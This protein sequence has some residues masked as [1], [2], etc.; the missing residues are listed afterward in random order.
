M[1]EPFGSLDVQTRQIMENDL[2][3]LW[4]E[5]RKTVLFVTHDLEEAIALADRV[6]V[7]SAGPGATVIGEYPVALPRPRDVAEI[8]LERAFTD[9]Y[10]TI[11]EQL[12][13]E[14]QKAYE[15]ARAS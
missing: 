3:R 8:R 5:F 14:V 15:R 13:R 12:S 11:W 4:G 7:L 2:L 9:L 10:R 6:V 1:D